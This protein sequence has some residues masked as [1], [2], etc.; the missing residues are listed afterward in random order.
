MNNQSIGGSST[1]LGG[2]LV[3]IATRIQER[4]RILV[5]EREKLQTAKAR[6][7]ELEQIHQREQQINDQY[8]RHFLQ[9]TN[10]RNE[11]ELEIFNVRDQIQ[12]AENAIEDYEQERIHWEEQLE[13][14]KKES[15]QMV[16]STYGPQQ[17]KM[18]LF[19][20][21]FE[22][23]VQ[24]KKDKIQKRRDRLEAIHKECET[25]KKQ[26]EDYQKQTKQVREEIETEKQTNTIQGDQEEI[27]A[28]SKRVRE[29]IA[30]VS[31]NLAWL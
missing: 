11:V 13:G 29:A 19:L 2:D 31:E 15:E 4:A 5:T 9:C 8:R 21:A 6:L 1:A 17:V 30:E 24:A 20:K 18:E 10:A 14:I 23:T 3:A 16:E 26:H 25:L 22:A 7:T 12:A 28:L 27:S